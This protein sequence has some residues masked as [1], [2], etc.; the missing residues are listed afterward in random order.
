MTASVNGDTSTTEVDAR[1]GTLVQTSAEGRVVREQVDPETLLTQSISVTGLLDS[2]FT[3]DAR[4]RLI[5]ETVGDR[6]TSYTFGS[7]GRGGQVTAITAADGKQTFYEYDLLGRV[8][9]VTYPDGHTT[10]SE[11]DENGNRTVLVVPTPADHDSA[12]NGIN[13]VTSE[14]TPPLGETTQYEYDRDRR[15]TAIELPSG[16]RLEHTYSQNRLTRTDTPEGGAIL[17]DY[18]HAIS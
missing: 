10:L 13:R 3:Y 12:Y 14:A 15:L 8:T 6:S 16:Q 5:Q 18:H 11:Y 4:G 17:Y 9:K 1:A 2:E 7:E